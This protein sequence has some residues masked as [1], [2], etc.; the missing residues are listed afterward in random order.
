MSRYIIF[1]IFEKHPFKRSYLFRVN[2]GIPVK[3]ARHHMIKFMLSKSIIKRCL[4]EKP[5]HFFE[6]ATKTHLFL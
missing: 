3:I 5:K 6:F 2:N 1:D 4:I